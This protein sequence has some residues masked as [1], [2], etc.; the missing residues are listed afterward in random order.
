[1]R[2]DIPPQPAAAESLPAHARGGFTSPIPWR[3]PLVP[4]ALVVGPDSLL[5]LGIPD[6]EEP[7]ALHIAAAR[8]ADT[9]LQNLS[10]QFGR[11]Q[12]WLQRPHRPGGPNDLEQV[13]SVRK[14]VRHSLLGHASSR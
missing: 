11:H 13:G 7:P 9:G 8:G 5:D 12:V 2:R 3:N 1:V 4:S 6:D 10:D 14:C